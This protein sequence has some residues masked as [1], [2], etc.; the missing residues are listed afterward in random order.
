MKKL[1]NVVMLPTEKATWPNCLWLGRISHQLHFDTSYNK[2]VVYQRE[3][4]DDSM[5]PQH[6]YVISNEEVREGDWYLVELYKDNGES[7]GIH[8]EQ[9]E[10]IREDIWIGV[11]VGTRH[12]NNCKKIIA[13]TDTSLLNL[14]LISEGFVKKYAE[15]QGKIDKVMVEFEEISVHPGYVEGK[16]FPKYYN[17]FK[18]KLRQNN[19]IIISKVIDNFTERD[20]QVIAQDFAKFI[21]KE[22][23]AGKRSDG[24]ITGWHE[25]FKNYDFNRLDK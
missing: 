17:D 16:G 18:P 23:I 11:G 25:W 5:L 14:P 8:I 10:I 3:P 2:S 22:T 4:I 13:S 12:K 21:Q 1:C 15:L 6:L 7:D 24:D 20:V 19:T 9:V